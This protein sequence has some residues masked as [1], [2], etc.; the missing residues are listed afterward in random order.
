[1]A[2][3]P[4]K[5]T[6]LRTSSPPLPA[7]RSS[8]VQAPSSASATDPDQALAATAPDARRAAANKTEPS[9]SRSSTA[10]SPKPTVTAAER[11]VAGSISPRQVC[12]PL[13]F[14]AMAICMDRR[15]R[16]PMYRPHAECE[17][18]IR[19]ADARRQSERNR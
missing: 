9:P 15:C 8:S 12:G 2:T 19:Y 17:A 6:P 4:T 10:T 14:F 11:A 18:Y 7:V 5:T 1:V 13:N 3:A 16:E